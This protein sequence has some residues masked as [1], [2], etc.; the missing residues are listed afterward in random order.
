MGRGVVGE[1]GGEIDAQC[2]GLMIASNAMLNADS[3]LLRKQ[4]PPTP[5]ISE[6]LA[7]G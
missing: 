3:R 5:R 6:A 2:R 1:R 4:S 7:S